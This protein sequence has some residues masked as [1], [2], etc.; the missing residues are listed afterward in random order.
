MAT[1]YRN[2]GYFL[3]YFDSMDSLFA[4]YVGCRGYFAICGDTLVYHNGEE[5]RTMSYDEDDIRD[6]F[7]SWKNEL[8]ENIGLMKWSTQKELL[9]HQDPKGILWVD[10]PMSP[11][12]SEPYVYVSVYGRNG[13]CRP[14]VFSR[15]IAEPQV[16]EITDWYRLTTKASTSQELYSVLVTL[17]DDETLQANNWRRDV[18]EPT[19]D[20]PLCWLTRRTVKPSGVALFSM[21]VVVYRYGDNI[22]GDKGDGNITLMLTDALVSILCDSSGRMLENQ[23]PS[24]ELKLYEGTREIAGYAMDDMDSD[25]TLSNG[26]VSYAGDDSGWLSKNFNISVIYK[27]KTY[28]AVWRIVKVI[29]GAD[30]RNA[31]AYSLGLSATVGKY[32]EG[33]RTQKIKAYVK[34][35]DG[36]TSQTIAVDGDEWYLKVADRDDASRE[37]V[38]LYGDTFRLSKKI[39][40]MPAMP[41]A[42]VGDIGDIGDISGG[43]DNLLSWVIIDGE[44][45]NHIQ[46]YNID[47]E[48]W[49][50]Q[51]SGDIRWDI[52]PVAA[53]HDISSDVVGEIVN[54]GQNWY[55]PDG[56]TLRISVNNCGRG[57]I[58]MFPISA[59]SPWKYIEIGGNNDD[60]P[61]I[62][63]YDD[64]GKV[65][66][67]IDFGTSTAPAPEYYPVKMLSFGN[68]TK[69]QADAKIRDNDY[70]NITV[71]RKGTMYY[72]NADDKSPVSGW[73]SATGYVWKTTGG[74]FYIGIEMMRFTNGAMVES[75]L[76]KIYESSSGR[77]TDWTIFNNLNKG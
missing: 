23:H 11:S 43:D 47:V 33:D 22:K 27:E 9:P 57:E 14:A 66:A 28:T 37:S 68:V 48:L 76:V 49:Q 8:D 39:T 50:K 44:G 58:R 13:W 77:T 34:S 35:N 26:V 56:Q 19:S 29:P 20:N 36:T 31:R 75:G 69:A 73:F 71:Y 46:A 16:D 12:S 18:P 59:S 55:A 38:R 53:L 1:N 15:H 64:D 3:G 45:I 7:D 30:G 70:Q 54:R 25:L 74:E 17:D 5:W 32:T 2:D 41:L 21:P 61:F 67:S 4:Q 72:N 63:K 60:E 40:Q 51:T 65:M 62:R 24:T 10:S 52:Q 6:I 42:D